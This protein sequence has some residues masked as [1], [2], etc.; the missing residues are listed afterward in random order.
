VS[1]LIV[2]E[3][4][5]SF[6]LFEQHE[7][8]KVSGQILTHLSSEAFLGEQFREAVEFAIT[9]H[10]IAWVPLDENPKWD[11]EN[12]RPFSFIDYPLE[13]KLTQYKKG[14]DK[15]QTTSEY[16]ALLCS[17]HYT[18]FF[19]SDSTDNRINHFIS[20]EIDRR[21][22]IKSRNEDIHNNKYENFH[23]DLL[24][25]CDDLSLYVCMNKPG[26]TKEEEISWFK[27]G[28][29]QRFNFAPNGL[30][31]KWADEQTVLIEPFPFHKSFTVTIPFKQ[32]SKRD[33]AEDKF[34]EAYDQKEYAYRKKVEFASM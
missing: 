4:N 11:Q 33:V 1:Y 19:K 31:A 29:R 2:L 14:I 34:T 6:L 21:E 10:D 7:H 18:S 24:Q 16:A 25:F 3:N 32:I 30:N 13:E 20:R 5:D 27:H 9:N 12:L 17:L 22:G 23:F 26:S 8:G 28:F 15:I